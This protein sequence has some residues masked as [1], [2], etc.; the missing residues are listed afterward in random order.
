MQRLI[1]AIRLR[2]LK[3][4]FVLSSDNSTN[5]TFPLQSRLPTRCADST[6]SLATSCEP[7]PIAAEIS[8]LEFA[9]A[10]A[11]NQLKRTESERAVR[12]LSEPGNATEAV[13]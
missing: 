10:H 13:R 3:A 4:L 11:A 1:G 7:A 8:N 12:S 6:V 2:I 5:C 9:L